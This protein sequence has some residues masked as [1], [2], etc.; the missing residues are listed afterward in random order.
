MTRYTSDVEVEVRAPA[1][2]DLYCDGDYIYATRDP[3]DAQ[4]WVEADP[5][6][7]TAVRRDG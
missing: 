6:Q 5:D 7:H 1:L 3:E 4:S 2:W